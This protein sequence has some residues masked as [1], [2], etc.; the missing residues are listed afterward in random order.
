MK[1]SAC[2]RKRI[3]EIKLRMPKYWRSTVILPFCSLCRWLE[4][5]GRL[6][7]IFTIQPDDF[8]TIQIFINQKLYVIL[9]YLITDIFKDKSDF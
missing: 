8:V 4:F 7:K 2:Y 9:L 6:S 3:T 1:S 5:Y